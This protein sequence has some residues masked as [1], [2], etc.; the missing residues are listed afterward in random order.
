MNPFGVKTPNR[1][2]E[3]AFLPI[4][5]GA[6]RQAQGAG[7]AVGGIDPLIAATALLGAAEGLGVQLVSSGLASVDAQAALDAQLAL[8]FGLP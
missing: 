7:G 2:W 5:S 8:V 1:C 3:H 6:A 4:R